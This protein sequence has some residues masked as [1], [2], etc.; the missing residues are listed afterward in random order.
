VRMIITKQNIEKIRKNALVKN[1]TTSINKSLLR[2]LIEVKCEIDGWNNLSSNLF[3]HPCKRNLI[4]NQLK[5]NV[6]FKQ[7]HHDMLWGIDIC[8]TSLVSR[9]EGIMLDSSVPYSK[10]SAVVFKMD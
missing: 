7:S 8:Y 1:N 10:R 4:R 2:K 3:L 5:D 9:N 6:G